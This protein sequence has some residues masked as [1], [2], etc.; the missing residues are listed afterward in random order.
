MAVD[1]TTAEDA[2]TAADATM[3]ADAM[4]A[5]DATNL[6]PAAGCMCRVC[7]PDRGCRV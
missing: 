1:A 4:M 2:T 7:R 6:R 5:A 3:A